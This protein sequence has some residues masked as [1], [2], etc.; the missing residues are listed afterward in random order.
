LERLA[1]FAKTL[2][3]NYF[4]L[5]FASF[6]RAFRN[7]PAVFRQLFA[8]LDCRFS[9]VSPMQSLEIFDLNAFCYR[10]VGYCDYT[11][12]ARY[13]QDK[14]C[15]IAGIRQR[16]V[17]ENKIRLIFAKIQSPFP[18]LCHVIEHQVNGFIN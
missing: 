18:D 7:Q 1:E 16:Q 9:P 12:I 5:S 10:S 6:A 14:A 13:T 17:K 2:N 11:M 4:H 3:I 15:L 8:T